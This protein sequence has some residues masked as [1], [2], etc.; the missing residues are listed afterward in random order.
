VAHVDFLKRETAI[1]ASFSIGSIFG[2]VPHM[3]LAVPRD[4]D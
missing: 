1:L 4:G 2:L 3:E